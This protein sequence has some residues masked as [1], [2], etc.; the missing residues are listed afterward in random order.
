MFAP[1]GS[2]GMAQL[3]KVFSIKEKKKMTVHLIRAYNLTVF[4]VLWASLNLDNEMQHCMVKLVFLISFVEL[5]IRH[6]K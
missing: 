1:L 2:G 6:Y 3:A 4:V 5:E